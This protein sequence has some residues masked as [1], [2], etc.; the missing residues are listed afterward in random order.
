MPRSST[1]RRKR[2]K[3]EYTRQNPAVHGSVAARV[4]P[5]GGRKLPECGAGYDPTTPPSDSSNHPDGFVAN[6]TNDTYIADGFIDV[7]VNFEGKVVDGVQQ[8]TQTEI[9]VK[10][11]RAGVLVKTVD[12][13]LH[14][15]DNITVQRVSGTQAGDVIEVNVSFSGNGGTNHMQ[16]TMTL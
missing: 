12:F 7:E 10:V 9:I 2:K 3:H 15:G 6:V 5:D 8:R 16:G 1:R 4:L 14:S 13:G 11:Y